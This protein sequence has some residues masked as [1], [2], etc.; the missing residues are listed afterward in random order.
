MPPHSD[1]TP[2]QADPT[3]CDPETLRA[4]EQSFNINLA[5][6]PPEMLS[7]VVDRSRQAGELV[8]GTP[9]AGVIMQARRSLLSTLLCLSPAGNTLF[10]EKNY[11]GGSTR[12]GV[13]VNRR[14]ARH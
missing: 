11:K 2:A 13:M 9:H 10:K 5:E 14:T 3:V 12:S 4:I 7:F 8:E 1:A 6:Q